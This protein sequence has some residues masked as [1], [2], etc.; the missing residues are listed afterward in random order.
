MGK[1]GVGGLMSQVAHDQEPQIV[2]RDARR[3]QCDVFCDGVIL[4]IACVASQHLQR[5]GP[6]IVEAILLYVAD[7][8]E[9]AD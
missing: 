3:L 6:I 5:R 2:R 1:D 8:L 4:A 7:R 9:R